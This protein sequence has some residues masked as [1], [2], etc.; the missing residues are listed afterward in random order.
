[1]CDVILIIQ[2]MGMIT[3]WRPIH[4]PGIQR[5]CPREGRGSSV[6]AKLFLRVIEPAVY[7]DVTGIIQ[8][9][10]KVAVFWTKGMMHMIRLSHIDS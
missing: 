9:E 4:V 3:R 1:M 5:N 8:F 10:T 7:S 6:F 2:R